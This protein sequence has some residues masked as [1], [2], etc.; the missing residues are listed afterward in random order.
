MNNKFQILSKDH[1][2]YNPYKSEAYRDWVVFTVEKNRAGRA[3]IDIEFQLRAQ[4][5]AFNPKGSIVEQKLID[6]KIIVE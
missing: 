3:M 2:A 5:F 6:E 1:I 4:Y